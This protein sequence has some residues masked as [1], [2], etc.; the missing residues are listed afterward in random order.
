[1][2]NLTYPLSL[3]TNGTLSMRR[4][5]KN[6]NSRLNLLMDFIPLQR[7]T[8]FDYGSLLS[9][10]EQ[11]ESGD[12]AVVNTVYKLKE[13]LNKYMK[14]YLSVNNLSINQDQREVSIGF[15]YTNK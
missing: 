15:N 6:N 5:N 12:A 13:L 4:V 9:R 1:M 7:P 10:V 11:S 2:F 3:T 8:H 14:N